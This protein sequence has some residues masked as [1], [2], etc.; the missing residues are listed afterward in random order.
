MIYLVKSEMIKILKS[1]SILLVWVFLL[2][3]GF[4]LIRK[5]DVLD[6]YADIFYK[7]EGSIPLIGLVMF[8][9]TSGNY[10]KEYDSNMT[11]LINTTKN[12]KKSVVLSKIIANG[13]VLSM[14]NISF[15]LLVGIRGFSFFY[16]QHL[17]EPIKNLWYFGNSN[18]NITV[19]Q[20]YLIVIVTNVFA[21]FIFAQIGLTLSSISKSSIMP[22]IL[23]GLIMAIPY[24][25][26]GFIPEKAIKFMSITPNWIMMSQQ[27]V[28]YNVPNILIGLSILI[29]I[30]LMIILTK[31]TYKNFTSSKRF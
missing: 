19:I 18:L 31:I 22:F 23:G 20:M 28:R 12:G 7:I 14:I 8:M 13:L 27:I 3:F 2:L 25:S 26:V 10:T 11:G 4:I 9:I 29:S 5:F 6:T 1:K 17:N 21:S 30:T 24:F 16:F 15:I